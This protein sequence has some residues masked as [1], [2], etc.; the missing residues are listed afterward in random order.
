M[1]CA[2]GTPHVLELAVLTT[3]GQPPA[4][5]NDRDTSQ[6][7]TVQ[8]STPA[9][10]RLPTQRRLSLRPIVEFLV[11]LFVAVLLCRTF[12]AEAY[13]VPTGS[14]APYILGFHKCLCC[15]Q[16][17]FPFSIGR[18][19]GLG[20]NEAQ[21]PGKPWEYPTA[22]CPNCGH[23]PIPSAHVPESPGDRLLV[24]KHLFDCR[25][26]RRWETAVFQG[27]TPVRPVSGEPFIKR[28]VGLPGEEVF[29]RDGDVWINGR[30][31]AKS[32]VE[33]QKLRI[34]VYDH[35]YQPGDAP[36]PFRFT[37]AD[38]RWKSR[39]NGRI[40]YLEESNPGEPTPCLTYSHL[41]RRAAGDW[42][43]SPITDLYAYNGDATGRNIVHDIALEARLT[44]AGH[45]ILH[46]AVRRG[47]AEYRL[48]IPVGVSTGPTTLSRACVEATGRT[49]CQTIART[50][51]AV[52]EL[53]PD[54]VVCFGIVDGRFLCSLG[55][56][57]APVFELPVEDLRPSETSS[58]DE[59]PGLGDR[60]LALGARGLRITARE[61][62]V[63]RDI[64]YTSCDVAGV[65]PHGIATPVRLGADEYYVLGDNSPGSYD[66]RRWE[67]GPGVPRANLVGKPFLLHLPSRA[68][69]Y[70]ILGKKHMLALP[71][72]SRMK[73]LQ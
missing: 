32:F 4:L 42:Q 33:W 1:K 37:A 30:R 9:E 65:F 58:A 16:C 36:Q 7:S 28:I 72:L 2:Q 73:I 63:Y 12:V 6:S 8:T 51:W 22:F 71:D 24:H 61:L 3:P 60:L 41:Q 45:G 20:Q 50:N 57:L 54:T 29:L 18:Q 66:S 40:W 31:A 70:H 35:D 59:H 62:K 14:M 55:S 27:P 64:Y 19:V 53:P 26:P 43:P 39:A 48:E 13:I 52:P 23:G 38:P 46:L 49:V 10:P 25:A 44:I 34:L 17:Q 21:A 69:E 67:S 5:A 15:P 56:S 47:Q 11:T 68:Q